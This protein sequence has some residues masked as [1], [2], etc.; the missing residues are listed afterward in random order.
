[1]KKYFKKIVMASLI[2]V[3]AFCF[4]N[5]TKKEAASTGTCKTCTA[6]GGVDQGVIQEEVCSEEAEQNFRAEHS[7]LNVTCQ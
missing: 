5:C 6:T 3:T 4:S 1:M 2:A 7:D